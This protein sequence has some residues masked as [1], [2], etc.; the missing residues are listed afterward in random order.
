MNMYLI[1]TAA[2]ILMFITCVWF[3]KILYQ[4]V[5][6]I[7]SIVTI[8][9]VLGTFIGIFIGLVTFNPKDIEASIPMLLGGLRF[10]FLTSIF[11]ILGSI[12]LKW[13]ALNKRKE[14]AALEVINPGATVDNLAGLL[15]SILDAE[16][17]EG[18]ETRKTL[19]SIEKS[20]TG[21]ADNTVMTQLQNILDAEKEEGDKTRETL[22]SIENSLTGDGDNTVM[23]QLQV[24]ETIFSNKQDKLLA[25]FNEFATKMAEDN[26][27]AL[28]KA[29]EE[30]MRDFNAKINE[31]F[32]DNFKQLNEAV[33]KI[34]EWQKL[35]GEQIDESVKQFTSVA[36]SI[37]K[38]RESLEII[39]NKSDAIVSSAEKLDPILQALQHQIKE[40]ENHLKAFSTLADDAHKAFPIITEQLDI[41]TNDFSTTVKEMIIN[42]HNSVEDQKT[43]LANQGKQLETMVGT[44]NGQLK[45]MTDD[46]SN[47]VEEMITNSHD[48]VED[49][50]TALANQSK[51]LEKTVKDSTNRMTQQI[52]VLDKALAEELT[53][54]LTL[55]GSQ[56]TSLSKQFVADYTPLTEQLRKV[57]EIAGSLPHEP[58]RKI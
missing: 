28:I 37:K 27:P 36:E 23:D 8:I 56:L 1:A 52:T 22:H 7:A 30:V 47:T 2:G 32:G 29:L 15:Q 33:G 10:A 11:G 46:F 55:L 4:Q 5:N 21:D 50:K 34:N 58:N 9:G 53:K 24:L 45:K 12:M 39:A 43:A 20:L 40:L 42:S 18:K 14:Q 41:L 48:S 6:A 49:Q 19:Q 16:K 17:K 25:S 13:L 57:V 35:Y 44:T 54:A 3:R 26:T 38:S 31:Q 51:Q